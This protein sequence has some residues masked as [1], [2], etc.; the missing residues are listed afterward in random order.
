[1]DNDRM[2]NLRQFDFHPSS[3]R[4]NPESTTPSPGKPRF[5]EGS[6]PRNLHQTNN[7]T[8]RARVLISKQNTPKNSDF[9]GKNTALWGILS[10]N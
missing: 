10:E 9:R 4:I 8:H 1:M 6:F 5:L 7:L 2:S 3:S